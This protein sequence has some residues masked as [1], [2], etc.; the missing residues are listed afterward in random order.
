MAFSWSS[1]ELGDYDNGSADGVAYTRQELQ[2]RLID[3]RLI[4][5]TL[6]GERSVK[7]AGVRYLPMPNAADR[8]PDNVERYQAYIQRAAYFPF[9]RKTLSGMVGYAYA[10]DPEIKLPNLLT[11]LETDSDGA[12][13]SLTQLS[14]RSLAHTLAY[15]RSGVFVDYPVTQQGTTLKELQDG[16]IHPTITIYNPKQ[17]RNWRTKVRGAKL[18][19]S[20]VVLREKHTFNDDGFKEQVGRQYRVLK[21][22]DNDVYTVEIWRGVTYDS[23]EYVMI[24]EESGTPL[25]SN[26]QTWNEIPF[27]FIGSENNDPDPDH[28]PML[29]LCNLNIAHY[30]NSADYE[31][32]VFIVGQPTPVISGLDERWYKEVMNEKVGF[33]SRGG[34]V[35]PTGG[36]ADLL[37]VPETTMAFEAMK[38]KE[39]QALALGAKLISNDDSETTATEAKIDDTSESSVLSTCIQNVVAAYTKALTW[40]AMFVGSPETAEF[41]INTNFDLSTM[42]A[43]TRLQLLKEWQ[44]GAIS[45]T[46]YRE[47]LRK[48][49]ITSQDDETAKSEIEAEEAEGLNTEV[50][51]LKALA[52]NANAVSQNG[53]PSP[54]PTPAPVAANAK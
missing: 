17:I 53:V 32:A 31:E 5:D 4:D 26:G 38:H 33:G 12:G 15:G 10:R 45:F 7:E 36:S 6:S 51:R 30:R 29:D 1:L 44:A 2:D 35:L 18:V 24:Q 47:N 19:L 13:L 22:T 40:C 54:T 42:D 27:S 50:A 8:S 3:Y 34:I 48:S 43:A 21:L 41:S 16:D 11:V 46:E 28:P 9:S 20:L 23:T 37:S 25:N 14:K 39:D 49:G 52:D